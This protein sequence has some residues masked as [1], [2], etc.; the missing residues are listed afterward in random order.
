[1]AVESASHG[2]PV[3]GEDDGFVEALSVSGSDL[4]GHL[5][6]GVRWKRSSVDQSSC[7]Q[8]NSSG[9]TG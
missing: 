7:S 5:D 4:D 1:M 6:P 9:C 2:I 3:D 8:A